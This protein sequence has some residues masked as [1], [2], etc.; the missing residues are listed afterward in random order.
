VNVTQREREAAPSMADCY[1]N[2]TYGGIS[3]CFNNEDSLLLPQ[4]EHCFSPSQIVPGAETVFPVPPALPICCPYG[5]KTPDEDNN[6]EFNQGGMTVTGVPCAPAASDVILEVGPVD[7]AVNIRRPSPLYSQQRPPLSLPADAQSEEGWKSLSDCLSGYGFGVS[8]LSFLRSSFPFLG[9]V[10]S[11]FSELKDCVAF[12]IIACSQALDESNRYLFPSVNQFLKAVVC[13]S[14]KAV[15]GAPLHF[16]T[17][18]ERLTE[19]MNM[20]KKIVELVLR[21]QREEPG[22]QCF[23]AFP[24]F[25]HHK[26][27]VILK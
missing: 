19:D 12:L 1:L 17:E 20:E 26:W 21:L 4:D 24:K 13:Y 6:K 7:A 15:C 10:F 2:N 18:C 5:A 16:F 25:F 23:V 9:T 22:H 14:V 11:R 8:Y 3:F 27:V